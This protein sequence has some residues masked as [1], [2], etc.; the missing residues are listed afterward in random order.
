MQP[1]RRFDLDT[2]NDDELRLVVD[3]FALQTGCEI[4]AFDITQE[5]GVPTIWVMVTSCD[6]RTHRPFRP[7]TATQIRSRPLRVRSLR[8]LGRY[9][10]TERSI[11]EGATISSAYSM[12]LAE[13]WTSTTT[14]NSPDCRRRLSDSNSCSEL[15]GTHVD[16]A[17][18]SSL[19]GWKPGATSAPRWHYSC[20]GSSHRASTSSW[21][22]KA[23]M[24]R[25]ASGLGLSKFSCLVYFQRTSGAGWRGSR[26]HLDSPT[27]EG[28]H[29]G[30]THSPEG[31]EK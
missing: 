18:P 13:W 22:T 7:R 28:F 11:V 15:A 5:F 12:T 23:R 30:H 9:G 25:L 4:H 31:A 6:P 2:L 1:C 20:V 26:A 29:H 8:S 3:R 16:S 17:T 27:V 14:Q 19:P 10:S 24:R 21:S